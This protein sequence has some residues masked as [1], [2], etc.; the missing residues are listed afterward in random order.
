LP[1]LPDPTC[2]AADASSLPPPAPTPARLSPPPP[3][4]P[5]LPRTALSPSPPPPPPPSGSQHPV[6]RAPAP[7]PSPFVLVRTPR[8][9][10]RSLRPLPR[11]AVALLQRLVKSQPDLHNFWPGRARRRTPGPAHRLDPPLASRLFASNFGS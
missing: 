2:L 4:V 10:A 8:A 1:P 9:P 11:Y 7:A 6:P 3:A 5:A